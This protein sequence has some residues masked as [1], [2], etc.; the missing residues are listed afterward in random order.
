MASAHRGRGRSTSRAA[1][2]VASALLSGCVAPGPGGESVSYS[3]VPDAALAQFGD[4]ETA[5][6]QDARIGVAAA[7][8]A[9]RS[10]EF[11]RP[12]APEAFLGRFKEGGPDTLPIAAGTIVWVFHWGGIREEHPKAFPGAEGTP[13]ETVFVYTDYYVFIDASNGSVIAGILR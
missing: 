8:D 2:L 10:G 1:I 13:F 6:P 3:P 11:D 5:S 9:A 7:L 12:G 4:F